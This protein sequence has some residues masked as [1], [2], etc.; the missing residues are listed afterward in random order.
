MKFSKKIFFFLFIFGLS[1]PV[2]L[3]F[4]QPP[5][6]STLEVSYPT[7]VPGVAPPQSVQ[8]YLPNYI[9]YL[10]TAAVALGGLITFGALLIGG[11]KYLTSVGNPAKM[12]DAR[13]Q[14]LSGILG[15]L[16]ILGSYVLVNM[17]NPEITQLRLPSISPSKEG[18]IIFNVPCSE[19]QN[20]AG[21]VDPDMLG[22]PELLNLPNNIFWLHVKNTTNNISHPDQPD[23]FPVASFVTFHS[24]EELTIDFCSLSD[25]AS[26][27]GTNQI[28][29]NAK[30]CVDI[31]QLG[32]ASPLDVKSI[33]FKWYRPGVW[34]FAYG[35]G[36][37]TNSSLFP[38]PRKPNDNCGK[39][40]CYLYTRTSLVSLPAGLF[41]HVEAIALVNNGEEKFGAILHN[42][43]GANP[44]EKGW[45]QIFLP[46]DG[47]DIALYVF[48]GPRDASSITVFRLPKQGAG[49][50]GVTI[51]RNP[52]CEE[53][54]Y[55]VQNTSGSGTHRE[56]MQPG[57]R[58]T[59]GSGAVDITDD[60]CN[61]HNNTTTYVFGRNDET[62]NSVASFNCPDG[63]VYW[64]PN[65]RNNSSNPDIFTHQTWLD[66]RT[67]QDLHEQINRRD[68]SGISA[69]YIDD[70]SGFLVMLYDTQDADPGDIRSA[71]PD[72]TDWDVALLN[73]DQPDL[74]SIHMNERTTMML[75]VRSQIMVQ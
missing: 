37:A 75:I 32:V 14:I 28:P 60:I 72:Q 70:G 1:I 6:T 38:D 18:I 68:P 65:D 74:S 27:H 22:L 26:C 47:A 43:P 8:T 2:F 30:N 57:I 31:T 15:L 59:L 7:L 4:A 61:E 45:A 42:I 35:A 55:E 17:I 20:A 71:I 67:N 54:E 24:S 10:Y 29:F 64:A 5:S 36:A 19:L 69:V 11:G 3:V 63:I 51:C 12:K 66:L 44:K 39:D 52:R 13:D 46:D 21:P 16:L 62:I 73:Y 56:Y 40:N 25:F 58:V 50:Y 9:R 33:R 49:N 48:Q 34:L 41:D 23:P 53:A